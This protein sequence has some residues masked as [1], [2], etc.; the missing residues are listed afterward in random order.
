MEQDNSTI[1]DFDFDLICEFFSTIPRQG[2]GSP[3]T[4]RNALRFIDHLNERST[5]CDLGYAIGTM[6]MDIIQE[7]EKLGDYVVN[8]V[9]ARMNTRQHY[10]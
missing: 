5:I 9:E 8:V 4:T 3:E 2:P 1:H 7:C 6:Y 10:V